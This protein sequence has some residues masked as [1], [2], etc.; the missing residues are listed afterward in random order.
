MFKNV[1]L[2]NMFEK[3]EM[4]TFLRYWKCLSPRTCGSKTNKLFHMLYPGLNKLFHMI[5]PGFANVEH[6]TQFPS[7][8]PGMIL[9]HV[10]GNRRFNFLNIPN[11]STL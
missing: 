11:V 2:L 7:A 9:H 1:E 3:V 5:Y 8:G 10:K 4:S 6:S